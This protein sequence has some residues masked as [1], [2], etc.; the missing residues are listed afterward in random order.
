MPKRDWT[1]DDIPDQ[2]GRFAIV[3]GANSGIGYE[4]ARA[5]AH[6]GADVVMAC[7]N[8]EKANA[9]AAQIR[10]ENPAGSVEVRQL[11]LGDLDS[12]RQFAS[13]FRENYDS[14][15]L[16]INNAGILIGGQDSLEELDI[17]GAEHEVLRDLAASPLRPRVLLV[18][19]NVAAI[20]H[21]LEAGLRTEAADLLCGHWYGKPFE[22]RRGNLFPW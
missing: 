14:L 16:L 2:Q 12:V 9:A 15:D 13:V 19:D 5:L 3:T 11:D 20:G 1:C 17:E 22:I 6:K 7:R 4:T 18:D 10:S 8:M 21:A